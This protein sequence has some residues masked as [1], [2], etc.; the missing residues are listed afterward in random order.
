MNDPDATCLLAALGEKLPLL[1]SLILSD[2]EF[3]KGATAE[4]LH[5]KNLRH[6]E[7]A[8]TMEPSDRLILADVLA[9]I[10]MLRHLSL[11]IGDSV[12]GKLDS[13]CLL[14]G[15]LERSEAAE[16]GRAVASL[17]HLLFGNLSLDCETI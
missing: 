7:L 12:S 5:L 17:E 4:L 6:L 11:F 10:R 8:C 14:D 15:L 16:S 1:E 9:G 2:F 13:Q 3:P